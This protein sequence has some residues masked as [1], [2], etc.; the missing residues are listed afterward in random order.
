MSVL[1][2]TRKMYFY[3]VWAL[4]KNHAR[5]EL[6]CTEAFG[7]SDPN[8]AWLARFNISFGYHF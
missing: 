2:Y 7:V 5:L 6:V 1:V 3:V 8:A 4:E